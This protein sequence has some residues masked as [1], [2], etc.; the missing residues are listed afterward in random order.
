MITGA[1]KMQNVMR[2]ITLLRK[3]WK[4]D[5]MMFAQGQLGGA[6]SNQLMLCDLIE[7]LG[8]FAH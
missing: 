6:S 3:L 1:V 7:P 2:M 4:W 5:D 8:V